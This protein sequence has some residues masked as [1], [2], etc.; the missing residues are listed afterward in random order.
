MPGSVWTAIWAGLA[1]LTLALAAHPFT[2]FPLS[3]R[4]LAHLRPRKIRVGVAPSRIAVCVCA[5]NEE[6]VIA[7]RVENL[8]AAQAALP[9]LDILFY[10]DAATDATAR[11]LQGYG[12]KIRLV[13]SP[14]RHGKT[15]GMNTL[16]AMTDADIVVFSDANVTFAPGAIGRLVAVFAD[17]EVGC[18]CGHLMY[19]DPDTASSTAATGSFYWRLEEHIKSMESATGSVM[20]ADGSIFALRRALHRPPP[21]HLID[22]MFVSLSVLCGGARVVRVPDAVAYEASVCRPAEEF[23]RKI[24]I[25]CQAFNV[26]RALWK[27]LMHLPTIDRYKYLSHKLLRWLSIYFLALSAMFAM[28]AVL[29]AAGPLAAGVALLMGLAGTAAIGAARRGPVGKLREVFAAL[30]ATGIGIARSVG[31]ETFQTWNPPASARTLAG[32]IADV[33]RA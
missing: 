13:V 27:P 25:A 4:L 20:G 28:L 3:L 24:R 10:V 22:D 14:E 1:I 21:P 12:E 26:N 5:Y 18:A 19:V 2:S 32:R 9:D 6:A 23:R 30:L 7:A 15:F 11:I 31:G 33:A 8:L 17:P 16:V 29:S